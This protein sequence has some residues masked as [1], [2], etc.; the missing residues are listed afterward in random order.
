MLEKIGTVGSP[1]NEFVL[2]ADYLLPEPGKI[3]HNGA[4]VVNGDLIV[5]TGKFN[6]LNEDQKQRAVDFGK[7]V[8]MPGLI[9]AHT[10]LELTNLKGLEVVDNSLISWIKELLKSKISWKEQDYT[11]SVRNGITESLQSGTT[12]VADI[13]SSGFSTNILRKSTVRNVVFSEVIEFAPSKSTEALSKVKDKLED[14][15]CNDLFKVGISPHAPYTV[16]FE[17]F[18]ECSQINDLPLCTHIAETTE[19]VAF[20][21]H[22]KGPFIDFLRKFGMLKDSWSAPGLSPI[23]YLAKSGILN[24]CPLLVHCNY[25]SDDDIVLIKSAGS[26]VVYCPRSHS[27]FGHKDHRFQKLLKTGVNVALG[28][29][30]LASNDSLSI[31]DEMKFIYKNISNIP[32]ETIFAMGTINGAHALGLAGKVGVLKKDYYADISII[33]IPHDFERDVYREL[34]SNESNNIFTMVNGV[35]CYDEGSEIRRF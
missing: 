28:T 31:L 19:E 22:G 29:D 18:K 23:A 10:H 14:I 24:V 20:L 16:S 34:F 17:L 12:T 5:Y 35:V 11:T 27:F 8:I 13:T 30:S 6:D 2:K 25:I 7:S 32:P 21:E 1:M 3:V 4:V 26:C 15:I 33:N 9:N